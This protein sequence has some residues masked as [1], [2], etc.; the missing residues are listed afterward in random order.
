[1]SAMSYI[2]IIE[3]YHE[4]R[5]AIQ[6][7]L[8]SIIT[9]I[10]GERLLDDVEAQRK[11]IQCLQHYPFVDLLYTLDASGM[12]TSDNINMHGKIMSASDGKGKDRSQRP[13]YLLA[14]DSASVVVTEPYLSSASRNC[15]SLP[16]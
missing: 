14:R 10:A 16:Q 6:E 13:Y 4:Y 12:Q 15:V 9:G 11:S 2:S 3:R 7:L 8:A 1:M 5:A